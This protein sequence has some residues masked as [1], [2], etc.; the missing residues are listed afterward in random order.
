MDILSSNREKKLLKLGISLARTKLGKR[1][2][3]TAIHDELINSNQP[4]IR[5]TAITIKKIHDNIPDRMAW[6]KS[7]ISE[8]GEFVLWCTIHHPK[9]R[10]IILAMHDEMFNDSE[11]SF[12]YTDWVFSKVDI[13]LADLILKYTYN[14][15]YDKK[16]TE[17]FVTNMNL[18][19]FSNPVVAKFND[20]I[21]K[22]INESCTENEVDRYILFSR[23][24]LYIVMHDT[25]YRDVFF[26]G[27]YQ[28]A[29]KLTKKMVEPYYVPLNKCYL[30]LYVD[31]KV[32]TEKLK[33]K[34]VLADY[35]KSLPEKYCV[36][37]ARQ[38]HIQRIINGGK[39][40]A[41]K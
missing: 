39:K 4:F 20:V 19:K 1:A 30:K 36:P 41:E 16:L 23:L 5:K 22:A 6:Q 13:Y 37:R 35:D 8:V 28:L 3:T 29:N 12:K 26:W 18:A 7:V 34:G 25:A 14:K 40:N 38:K 17:N 33:E 31:A 11:L 32:H 10:N 15:I 21:T 27:T 2:S 24:L 9:Y